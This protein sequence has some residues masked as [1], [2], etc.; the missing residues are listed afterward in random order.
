[1]NEFE[2]KILD[3]IQEYL[4]FDFLDHFM[5]S[6]TRLAD[7]GILWIVLAAMLVCFKQT[8][9]MGITL[10]LSLIFGLF[11]CNVCLKNVVARIRPY[12][13]N[14]D[15]ILLLERLKD[16]AFPSGHTVC[17]FEAATVIYLFNKQWGRAV[18][19]LSSV[20]AFSRMY[21]YM[22]YPTDVLAGAVIGIAMGLLALC[23]VNSV[24]KLS[25]NFIKK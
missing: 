5:V 25:K 12:D 8:R 18:F 16:F 20:I 22:H 3:F 6:I 4:R 24:S 2:I 10:S 15:V 7:G 1:M 23:V 14:T 21:L 19:V 11:V 17:S 9:K 13:I